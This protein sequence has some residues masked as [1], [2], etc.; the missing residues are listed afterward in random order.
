MDLEVADENPI[1]P[2]GQRDPDKETSKKTSQKHR[3][4][5]RMAMGW[6]GQ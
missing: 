4:D 6:T 1:N 2:K 3:E 5:R